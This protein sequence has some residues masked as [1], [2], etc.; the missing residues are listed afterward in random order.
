MLFSFAAP[1]AVTVTVAMT[2]E[3]AEMGFPGFQG[4]GDKTLARSALE[5]RFRR[6]VH[7]PAH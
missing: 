1:Q 3:T 5:I 6:M 2:W 7:S 4:A